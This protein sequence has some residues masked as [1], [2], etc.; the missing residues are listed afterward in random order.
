MV[1]SKENKKEEEEVEQKRFFLG[2]DEKIK[3]FIVPPNASDIR[4]ADWQ[5][6]RIYTKSLTEG[7][8]TSAEM[9]DILRRRGI[10]G[11]EFE[12]RAAELTTSL[13][14]KIL[15]LTVINDLNE[16][17]DIAVEVSEA[18]D[19]L[20][21]WNQRLN[22]PMANTC[23]QLA[24]DSRLEYLTSCMIADEDNN[25]I[26]ETY[27][28]YIHEKDQTLSLKSRFEVML[29]LQGLEPDFLEKTPEAVAMKEVETDIL[30]KAAEAAKALEAIQ[31]EEEAMEEQ[32]KEVPVKKVVKRKVTRKRKAEKS[33]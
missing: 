22:G 26:W 28:E 6:S 2:S 13:N 23:E 31:K 19:E 15:S 33:E 24:D 17:R 1:K 32:E 21:Q 4:D 20:F 8:T 10:V 3:Y 5:Y 27:D 16:K 30:N 29:Y 9:M 7:I 11:P 25:R 18:R 14:E 12:Q